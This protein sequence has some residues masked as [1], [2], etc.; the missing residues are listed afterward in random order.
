MKFLFSLGLSTGKEAETVL[1]LIKAAG[2]DGV[3]PTLLPEGFPSVERCLADA[4]Q[5]KRIAD[6]YQ[7]RI[8][9][10]RGGPLFWSCFSSSDPELQKQAVALL[11]IA[12]QTLVHMGGSVLLVVP[13]RYESHRKYDEVYAHAVAMARRAADIAQRYRITIGLENVHNQFLLGASEWRQFMEEVGRP[14]IRC[15]Y[16][17]GNTVYSGLG[18]PADWIRELGSEWICRIHVKDVNG[19]GEI[20]PL[21]AGNIDWPATTG[22]LARIGYDDWVGVELPLPNED[23]LSF[24]QSAVTSL[25]E[26]WPPSSNN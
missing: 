3:E 1:P 14:E 23:P 11:E 15:Y 4:E 26:I 20:V 18:N 24:L 9:S 16:D 8:P 5:L 13:G 6:R 2:F 17:I 7:L 10:M 12:A 25:H 19:E 22:C 21:L